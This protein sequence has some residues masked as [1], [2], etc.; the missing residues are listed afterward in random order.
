MLRGGSLNY[1]LNGEAYDVK[2]DEGETIAQLQPVGWVP[3]GRV[4]GYYRVR[5]A[6]GEDWETIYTWE[7]T[8]ARLNAMKAALTA[9]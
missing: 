8:E 1:L 3:V 7:A 9:H 4:L 2:D 5:R 6:T